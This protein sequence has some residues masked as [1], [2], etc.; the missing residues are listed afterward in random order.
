MI[1]Q[2]AEGGRTPFWMDKRLLRHNF[3]WK[4]R[5]FLHLH[6]RGETNCETTRL[7]CKHWASSESFAVKD[8]KSLKILG[9]FLINPSPE[10]S[11]PFWG[12][13]I[14][15]ALAPPT[16]WGD[17]NGGLVAKFQM[18]EVEDSRISKAS[19]CPR[20][21]WRCTKNPKVNTNGRMSKLDG[22]LVDLDQWLVISSLGFFH[23]YF[24]AP[25]ISRIHFI[26]QVK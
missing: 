9:Q 20:Q 13:Y 7:Q 25:F 24:F 14:P 26:S 18:A 11:P 12:P 3:R 19:K 1:L 5:L 15:Y 16:I 17:R 21:N 4:L 8:G 22:S 23:P 10:C 2:L 6:L